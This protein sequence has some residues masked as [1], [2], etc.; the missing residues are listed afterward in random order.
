MQYKI[1]DVQCAFSGSSWF[2]KAKDKQHA[3]DQVVKYSEYSTE[4]ENEFFVDEVC[5][6]S[7]CDF[8]YANGF[9]D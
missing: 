4:Y 2:V 9:D 5:D 6:L 3:I 8:V 7:P 1:Y